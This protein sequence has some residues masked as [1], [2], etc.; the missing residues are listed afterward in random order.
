MIVLE[1]TQVEQSYFTDRSKVTADKKIKIKTLLE[2][3]LCQRQVARDSN[4]SQTCVAHVSKKLKQNL[5]LSNSIGQGRKK[6]STQDNDR[7]LSYIMKKDRT[8]SSQMLAAEWTLSNGKK[9]CALT[10]RRRL[11]SMGYKSY[12]AKRKLLRTPAQIKKRLTFDKYHQYWS[13]EWNNVIWSGEAHFEVFNR[14]NRTLVRRLKLENNELFNFVS[15]VKGGGATVSVRRQRGN[16]GLILIRSFRSF[17]LWKSGVELVL[18]LCCCPWYA[19][20]S[21]ISQNPK[22]MIYTGKMNG[23]AYITTI[24]DALPMFIGNAFDTVNDNWIN[25]Q[26]NAPP[27]TYKYSMKW[28]KYNNINVLKWPA[29]SSDLNA[30]DSMDKNIKKMHTNKHRTIINDDSRFVDWCST[31]QCQKFVNSMLR[32]VKQ[33]ILAR[34]KVLSKY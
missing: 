25:M 7:Q 2:I 11:I 30:I 15:R 34:G 26:D 22:C 19:H 18:T 32:R 6:A 12:T 17:Q 5:P 1:A 16:F 33:C 9:L 10:V 13:N 3:G 14:K 29:S 31:I 23:P 24:Q 8:K 4:V 27:H 28:F 20:Y 21:S